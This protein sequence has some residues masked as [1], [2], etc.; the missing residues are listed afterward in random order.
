[1]IAIAVAAVF[2]AGMGI[3]GITMPAA[4]VRP[5]GI[6]AAGPDA[7]NEV[8]AAPAGLLPV[9]VLLRCGG[10]PRW[11]AVVRGELS[12]VLPAGEH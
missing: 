5:F 7:R 10:R 3:Y 8:R 1:M 2:F 11:S 4:L 6:V 12:R 9:L